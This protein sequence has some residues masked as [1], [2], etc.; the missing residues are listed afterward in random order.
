MIKMDEA[1][2]P[3]NVMIHS[4]MFLMAFFRLTTVTKTHEPP[5]SVGPELCAFVASKDDAPSVPALR[6]QLA[7]RLPSYAVPQRIA[8][9]ETSAPVQG[10]SDPDTIPESTVRHS[11][12]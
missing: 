3:K 12:C 6:A 9:M 10:F 4:P 2:L 5:S 1:K 8:V 7:L 11:V